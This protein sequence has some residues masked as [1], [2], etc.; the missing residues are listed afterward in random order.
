MQNSTWVRALLLLALLAVALWAWWRH[1]TRLLEMKRRLAWSEE[2]RFQLEQHA[3]A[4][5]AK[6]QDMARTLENQQ[7]ALSASRDAAVRRAALEA[8]LDNAASHAPAGWAD[9]QPLGPPGDR[10]VPT[11]P[12]PLE[13]APERQR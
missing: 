1:R 5:D 2:S 9:T 8:A 7:Q 12:A 11:M 3:E 13:R 10:Y 4:V 6:M